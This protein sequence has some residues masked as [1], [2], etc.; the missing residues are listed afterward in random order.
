MPELK[1]I[2]TIYNGYRFRSRLEARW[3]VFFDALGVPYE[4][5]REGYDL[6]GQWYLPD[7]WLPQG[8]EYHTALEEHGRPLWIEIK[9]GVPD[10][11]AYRKASLLGMQSRR[12]VI[13]L[14][15][16]PFA[17]QGV[18]AYEGFVC[19]PA[20]D[21]PRDWAW[22]QCRICGLLF[23]FAAFGDGWFCNF[24]REH[25]PTTLRLRA[26]AVAFDQGMCTELGDASALHTPLLED[27]Y[28]R[29]RQARF[30]HGHSGN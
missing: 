11:D 24:C 21:L 25:P 2:E 26:N 7:F 23:L 30:E 13:I 17:K 8:M 27:A 4:Y 9:A 14:S 6:D 10:W 28:R 12:P 22:Q 29:A 5:E 16:Q 20:T 1:A 18:P 3:A 19:P 15:G